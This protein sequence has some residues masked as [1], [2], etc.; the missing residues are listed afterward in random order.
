[1]KEINF[2]CDGACK[3]N[4]KEN[5]IGGWGSHSF[6]ID[7]S[8][9]GGEIG[10]TNNRME[11]LAAIRTLQWIIKNR[12]IDRSIVKIHQLIKNYIKFI[13]ILIM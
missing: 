6:D 7:M 2:Y 11:L 13:L 12:S 9:H 3:G 4:G 5:S 8:I 1:M 10:T